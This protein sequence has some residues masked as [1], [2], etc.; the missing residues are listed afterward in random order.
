MKKKLMILPFLLTPLV[1]VSCGNENT[2]SSSDDTPFSFEERRKISL[3]SS[4][5]KTNYEVGESFSLNGL[6]VY[7][8]RYDNVGEWIKEQEITNYTSSIEEGTKLNQE[9]V[10]EVEISYSTY[11]SL[12]Y[13]IHVVSTAGY[14][15][16]EDFSY[17]STT[18]VDSEGT[19]ELNA[20]TLG[21]NQS[22]TAYLDPKSKNTKV[23][24]VPYYFTDSK[25]VA[26]EENRKMIQD[27]FFG[28]Q[29]TAEGHN[30][31]YSVKSY[32]EASSENQLTF[33]G[34]VLPWYESRYGNSDNCPQGA[35]SASEDLYARYESEY[36]KENHG[37]LGADAPSWQEFDGDNDGYIDLVWFVYSRPMEHV[38]TDQWWAYT[39][40]TATS[41][42][43][44]TAHPV[45][46]T[47]CWASFSFM[48]DAYDPHTFIHETGHA[49]GLNDYYC[50]NK[51][52]SPMG[53]L[54]MMDNNIGD[55]DAYSK[56][57][58]GWKAPLV[59]DENAVITLK[60]FAN[61]GDSI[62]LPS[63]NYNGTAFDEYF[64]LEFDGPYGLSKADYLNGYSGLSGF[65]KGGLRILHVD[66]RIYDSSRFYPLEDN[67]W[68]GRNYC[69]DNSQ[70]GRNS[71]NL[72]SKCTT[73]YFE[74]ANN[75]SKL[76]RSYSLVSTI[77]AFYDS[78]RNTL[79][80]NMKLD[81]AALFRAGASWSLENS[82]H[83]FMPSYSNLWNKARSH[84]SEGVSIN[85][86]YKVPYNVRVLSVS[87]E[88]MKIVITVK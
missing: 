46:K 66:S 13:V 21:K 43:A 40:H 18:Y 65:K 53:G 47:A 2:S 56:F 45:I 48:N 58:L 75:P 34:Y 31:P 24:V 44:S 25:E 50:Y 23:L 84:N 52:W 51:S 80:S 57:A 85:S 7:L 12:S 62:L 41:N 61:G 67:V 37:R 70:F 83:E 26:T 27:T 86:S 82:Y 77:P 16:N 68:M 3:D 19:H 8:L 59:V 78:S 36:A 60:P 9:G 33:D 20:A 11:S 87:D 35:M 32:Y 38:G 14:K 29:E 30:M 10:I 15:S 55:H 22:N 69:Y 76:D 28:S 73:D 88:E 64:L 1:L 5:A 42:S 72:A 74:G 49:Y 63:P 39:V 54:A 4:E 79:N 6:K 71:S 81:D 17:A